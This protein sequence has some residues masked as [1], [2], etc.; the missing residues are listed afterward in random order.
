MKIAEM[1]TVAQETLA[2][3]IRVMPDVPFT[4]NDIIIE[5]AQKGKLVERFA[6]LCA[7]C[8]PRRVLNEA[9]QQNLSETVRGNAIIGEDKSA[10]IFRVDYKLP[11]EALRE[12]MLHEFMHI[13]CAKNEVDGEHFIDIY[14][15]GLTIDDDDYA[16]AGYHL[17][18]EFIAQHYAMVHCETMEPSFEMAQ[19]FIF[20]YI[21]EV[22]VGK[23]S[24]KDNLAQVFARLLNC[25]DFEE[26]LARIE[27]DPE[28]FFID[29]EKFGEQARQS[30]LRILRY[31]RDMLNREKPWKID[32][33][34]ML[35]LGEL[36]TG[37]LALNTAFLLGAA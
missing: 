5:F 10:V 32:L 3:F 25:S 15:N 37:F 18:S 13:F 34:Q 4:M 12:V 2:D 35:D 14:G 21:C 27:N 7:V 26:V 11:E 9:Q 33:E 28:F 31:L 19:G 23:V 30:F 16:D 8:C 6:A 29:S 36:Y 22:V 20:D 1:K 24:A 17:W